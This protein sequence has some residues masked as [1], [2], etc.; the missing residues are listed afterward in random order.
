MTEETKLRV[1]TVRLI[2]VI[3]AVQSNLRLSSPST[4]VDACDAAVKA[5]FA[6]LGEEQGCGRKLFNRD[7][8]YGHGYRGQSAVREFATDLH[9]AFNG[10]MGPLLKRVR[11]ADQEAVVTTIQGLVTTRGWLDERI[12]NGLVQRLSFKV[13]QR[14]PLETRDEI[15]GVVHLALAV[16]AAEGSFDAHL[17]RGYQPSLTN[18]QPARGPSDHG[19]L[20]P[21]HGMEGVLAGDT[22]AVCPHPGGFV[23]APVSQKP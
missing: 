20:S 12:A 15:R 2:E 8:V 10:R 1:R 23:A 14:F 18:K 17:R 13:H 11:E 3:D 6:S 16:W 19:G 9:A 22:L 5:A 21:P 4:T 7:V